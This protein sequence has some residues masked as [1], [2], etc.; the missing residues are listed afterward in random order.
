MPAYFERIPYQAWGVPISATKNR[1]RRARILRRLTH[2]VRRSLG[3]LGQRIGPPLQYSNYAAWLRRESTS[4]F[5]QNTLE[6][7]TALYGEY[8][9]V[10][11]T[12][13]ALERHL[14]GE[15]HADL[16][17]RSLTLEIWLQQV[18]AGRFRDF[19]SSIT[20]DDSTRRAA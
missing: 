6:S 7:K 20:C 13:Y 16:I 5:I 15:N 3:K 10:D 14:R 17:C 9:P 1:R 4:S 12:L 2:R 11:T 19:K 18:F 8:L